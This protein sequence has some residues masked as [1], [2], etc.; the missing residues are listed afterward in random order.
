MQDKL[1]NIRIGDEVS[2]LTSTGQAQGVCVGWSDTA[3]IGARF[4]WQ[5]RT[6]QKFILIDSDTR[7]PLAAVCSRRRDRGC[8]QGVITWETVSN[9]LSDNLT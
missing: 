6:S 9:K 5:E 4:L 3:G 1:M 2:Y 8:N 7:I